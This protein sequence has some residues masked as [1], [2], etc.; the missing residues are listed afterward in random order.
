MPEAA[1]HFVILVTVS[2]PEEGDRIADALVGERLAACVNRLDGVTSV[3]RWKGAVERATESLLVIKTRRDLV[4]VLAA[5][6]RA[7]HSY[8][9][10]EVVA[11]PIV[12]GSPDYL[13]WISAE[14]GPASPAPGEAP[15]P[16]A[17]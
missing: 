2:S 3:Y 16:R 13:R 17:P 10:P 5:R 11:L 7:L 15:A 12:A 8:S 4:D 1:A 6:V 14:T 9:V